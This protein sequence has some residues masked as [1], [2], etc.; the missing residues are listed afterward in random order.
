MRDINQG[1]LFKPGIFSFVALH[2]EK[3]V[4][5][6]IGKV[7][8]TEELFDIYP[9]LKKLFIVD[10]RQP[11]IGML[12]SV[13]THKDYRGLGIG[14]KLTKSRVDLLNSLHL[15]IITVA[16]KGANGTMAAPVV[17]KFGLSKVAEIENCWSHFPKPQGLDVCM[18]C[19][20]FPCEC[21][22]EIY[23]RKYNENTNMR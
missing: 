9:G 8:K 22:A 11:F 7:I 12:Q 5:F 21:S 1:D 16:W 13:A 17:K 19:D 3:V 18:G 20:N 14:T 4:G 10:L 15:D 2:Q 23:F 6:S